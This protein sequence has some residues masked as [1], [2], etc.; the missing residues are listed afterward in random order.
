[1]ELEL[2]HLAA[3]LPYKLKTVNFNAG[4]FLKE[5]LISEL[6]PSNI[7][8][9]VDGTTESKILLR[10]LSDLTKEIEVN[11]EKLVPVNKILEIFG[12]SL[13]HL[14]TEYQVK[15]LRAFETDVITKELPYRY[16]EK[17]IE[18]HFDVFSLIPDGLAIDINTLK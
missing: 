5:P 13:K 16:I 11:G 2:K 9:F 12:R 4:T 8:R 17:L 14:S 15:A 18:W 7:L 1:M 6:I 10:P 3:Y